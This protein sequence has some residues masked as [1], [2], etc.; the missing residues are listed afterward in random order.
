MLHRPTLEEEREDNNWDNDRK[1]RIKV[2]NVYR[3]QESIRSQVYNCYFIDDR[4]L[5]QHFA[6][7]INSINDNVKVNGIGL[8][9]NDYLPLNTELKC[10][11]LLVDLQRKILNKM[12]K[13]SFETSEIGH[14]IKYISV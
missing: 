4:E 7:F 1:V 11:R 8:D 5:D 14:I 9:L 3:S 6:L 10:N 2:T 13:I 12:I